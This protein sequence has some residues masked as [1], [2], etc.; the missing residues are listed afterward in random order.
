MTD[1][2]VKE[3]TALS[4]AEARPHPWLRGAMRATLP[5][6]YYSDPDVLR[7]EIE[8]VFARHWQ[9]VGHT[10]LVPEPGS[11][12]AARVASGPVLLTRDRGG[13]LR[14]FHNVC[15]HR[16]AQLVDGCQRRSTIQCPYHAWTYGLD[17][18]LLA[19]PRSES[20]EDF[21]RE[22]FGLEPL[23]VDV[24]GPFV[25]VNPD[26]G[27][28]PLAEALGDLPAMSASAGI[29]VERLRFHSRV[30]SSLEANWKICCENFLECYHCQVAHPGLV[31]VLDVSEAAY[32]LEEVGLLSSQFGPLKGGGGATFDTRGEVESG[33]FHFLFPNLTLN[34]APGR[35]NLSLGPV[36]PN[37][38]TRT[39]RFLDYFFDPDA[40]DAWIS[41]FLEWDRQVGEEDAALVERVQRGVSARPSSRGVLL[42]SERLIAHFGELLEGAL[43]APDDPSRGGTRDRRA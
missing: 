41:A 40:D 32:R 12:A 28:S 33:Q 25:F 26:P 23:A 29:D 42:R 10:G 19:A 11:V 35:P 2:K 18:S 24:W 31:E 43:S 17:G 30:Q 5:F 22:R 13:A 1:P 14:A 20:E 37:G 3:R 4:G 15:R 38:P 21:E 27:A 34:V 6:S 36:L 8:R 16:G 7:L 39:T 9:Y